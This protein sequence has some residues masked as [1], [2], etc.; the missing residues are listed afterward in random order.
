LNFTII[1]HPAHTQF[2]VS[3]FFF[4]LV[5]VCQFAIGHGRM[6]CCLPCG[7]FTAAEFSLF[8]F[9]LRELVRRQRGLWTS[10]NGS[11]LLEAVH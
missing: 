4:F 11:Q 8:F 1:S 10:L 5:L 2:P 9:S 6:L 3:F 7:W